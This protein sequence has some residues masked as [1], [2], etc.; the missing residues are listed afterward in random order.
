MGYQNHLVDVQNQNRTGQTFL[1]SNENISKKRQPRRSSCALVDAQR[2]ASVPEFGALLKR[3]VRLVTK[4]PVTS[5]NRDDVNALRREL[6]QLNLNLKAFESFPELRSTVSKSRPSSRMK[7]RRLVG[8]QKSI[9]APQA[10][11][12]SG[13]SH[14]PALLGGKVQ[15]HHQASPFVSTPERNRSRSRSRMKTKD[16]YQR[17]SKLVN[18]RMSSM[19]AV[20]VNRKPIS[21]PHIFDDDASA[22]DG[23]DCAVL[24]NE[25][26]TC[27]YRGESKLILTGGRNVLSRPVSAD[28]RRLAQDAKNKSHDLH[29]QID[30][31]NAPFVQGHDQSSRE[32]STNGDKKVKGFLKSSISTGT[33]QKQPQNDPR[34]FAGGGRNVL[35]RPVSADMRRL[36]QDAKNKARDLHSQIDMANAP[37]VQ[38]HDQSSREPSTNGDKKVKGFL[39]RSLSIGTFQKQPQ[40]D[41]ITF[42]PS[43]IAEFGEWF[44]H[45]RETRVLRKLHNFNESQRDSQIYLK[46]QARKAYSPSDD[47]LFMKHIEAEE[48]CMRE[49]TRPLP[50][51]SR[52]SPIIRD[53][54]RLQ[55][56]RVL[57]KNG[58]D[59]GLTMRFPQHILIIVK[60]LPGNCKCCDCGSPDGKAN[61]KQITWASVAH[62]TIHCEE[63][64]FRHMT[65]GRENE[66]KNLENDLDWT[67]SEIVSMLEGGNAA[68]LLDIHCKKGTSSDAD[69]TLPLPALSHGDFNAIY[70]S[71]SSL[72]YRKMLGE[73]VL[74][75]S[76]GDKAMLAFSEQHSIFGAAT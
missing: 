73:K 33:F 41:P 45:C 16:N 31:A 44:E 26:R 13:A 18:D 7:G 53:A 76:N 32:P 2:H 62:G 24:Q 48:K 36:A 35:S 65:Q 59:N 67:F 69:S 66:I 15:S 30:M 46:R 3:D 56:S 22:S 19:P 54:V 72:Q 75:I 12:A 68:F 29:S 34:T 74:K 27:R 58:D 17:G 63:C 9:S 39:K 14:Y 37:F 60:F 25:D 51:N 1:S 4:L 38:G 57:S 42:D 28:M 64:A 6:S 52:K 70:S 47:V 61:R 10:F 21:A 71:R 5:A 43:N 50:S 8:D 49:A 40:N 55:E 20:E 11:G 23:S